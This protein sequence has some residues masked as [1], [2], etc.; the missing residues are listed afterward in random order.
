MNHDEGEGDEGGQV[1]NRE[2]GGGGQVMNRETEGEAGSTA[3][4]FMT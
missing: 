2:D 1:M 3:S 4:R